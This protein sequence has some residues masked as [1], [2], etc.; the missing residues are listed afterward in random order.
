MRLSSDGV[1]LNRERDNG[2]IHEVQGRAG[3]GSTRLSTWGRSGLE[4]RAW[5][6]GGDGDINSFP[7]QIT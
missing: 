1:M 3:A 5:G 6:V 2:K 7:C 4:G